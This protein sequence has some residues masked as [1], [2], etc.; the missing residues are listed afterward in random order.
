MKESGEK[1]RVIVIIV[2]V[3]IIK[4]VYLRLLGRTHFKG[5]LFE[6]MHS[7]V[8]TKVVVP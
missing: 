4:V 2:V 8:F 5:C 6:D 3:V 7:L 1:K